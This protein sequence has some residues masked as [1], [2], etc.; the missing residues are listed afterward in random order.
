MHENKRVRR[1]L[2]ILRLIVRC[3]LGSEKYGTQIPQSVLLGFKT[4][5]QLLNNH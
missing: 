4:L 2:L 5:K 1:R 3:A